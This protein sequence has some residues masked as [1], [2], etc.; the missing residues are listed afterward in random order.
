V[1]ATDLAGL[2]LLESK[3]GTRIRLR[4]KPGG[5]AD[6]ILGVHDGALRL[7]VTAPPDRGKANDAVVALIAR[8]LVIP[9]SAVELVAGATSR[10]KAVVVSIDPETIRKRLEEEGAR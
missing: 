4:V 6:A 3:G 8:V 10:S 7:S 2:D 9:R 5:S 1:P